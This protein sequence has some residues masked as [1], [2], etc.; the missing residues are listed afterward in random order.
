LDTSSQVVHDPLA[1]TLA[2]WK[3]VR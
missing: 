3:A 2:R 1:V